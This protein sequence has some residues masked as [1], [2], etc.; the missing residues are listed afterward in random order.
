MGDSLIK[1]YLHFVWG[2]WDRL[3]IITQMNEILVYESILEKCKSVGATVIA[4]GGIS[5]HV[6]L[7]V[8]FP[9]TITVANFIKGVKGSTSHLITHQIHP[10]EFFKW[11]GSYAVFS[12]S[13]KNVPRIKSYIEHQKE[14]HGEGDLDPIHEL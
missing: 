12:V 10:E 9:S 13:E 14:H 3:P 4:I 7:L 8:R 1:I 11:Q 6:H 5:D 2:T